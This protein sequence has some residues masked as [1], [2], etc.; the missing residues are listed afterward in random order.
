MT[1]FEQ[2]T[3]SPDALGA[4]LASLPV[5]NSPWD[6]AFHK[7]VCAKCGQTDCDPI[8][9][10]QNKRNNPTWWLKQEATPS[11]KSVAHPEKC[12]YYKEVF[13]HF[14][15]DLEEY[16]QRVKGTGGSLSWGI[17]GTEQAADCTADMVGFGASQSQ[18]I[19]I[20]YDKD[21][22]SFLV[23]Q[24]LGLEPWQ[25]K[26]DMPQLLEATPLRPKKRFRGLA[27]MTD[28]EI[29]TFARGVY[30]AIQSMREAKQQQQNS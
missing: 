23:R 15:I 26:P 19:I 13:A 24:E 30:H 14:G 3:A 10:N 17:G 2:I 29:N 27:E 4:F 6:E 11:D 28:E 12:L 7:E 25:S 18:R 16:R 9:P 20:D 1:I 22:G 21:F 5:A 8:Y